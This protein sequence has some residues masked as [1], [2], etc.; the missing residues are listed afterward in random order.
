MKTADKFAIG[1][2]LLAAGFLAYAVVGLFYKTPLAES[3]GISVVY[4]ELPVTS[5]WIGPN[6]STVVVATNTARTYLEIQ[7]VGATS[8]QAV[9]CNTNGRAGALYTGIVIGPT[10]SKAWDLDNMYQGALHCRSQNASTTVF[11][12]ER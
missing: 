1:I 10:S 6:S 11:I 5:A 8:S 3:A 12:Q 4:A 7:N 2:L 9:Y